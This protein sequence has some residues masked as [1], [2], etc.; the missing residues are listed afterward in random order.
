MNLFPQPTRT[1]SSVHYAPLPHPPI[2]KQTGKLVA[3]GIRP[4]TCNGQ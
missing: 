2:Q 1:E 3:S 4:T